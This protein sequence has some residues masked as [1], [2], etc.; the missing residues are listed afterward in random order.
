[1]D[2]DSAIFYTSDL[3]RITSYYTEVI[4]LELEYKNDNHYASFKLNNNSRLGIKVAGKEREVP[5]K[6]TVIFSTN[7][8]DKLCGD[9]KR[10]GVTFY[11]ELTT[12]DWGRHFSILDS[13]GNKVEF[14]QR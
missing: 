9:L 13:D 6:Q 14:V 11:S 3:D 7:K 4:G 2:L 5:G 8:V 12:Y 10:K 1:M